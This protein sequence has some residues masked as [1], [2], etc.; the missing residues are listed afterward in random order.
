M[1]RIKTK[2]LE[3][4]GQLENAYLIS[5]EKPFNEI[6]QAS[7]CLPLDDPKNEICKPFN[8]VEIIDD[9]NDQYIGLFRIMPSLTS[10][11]ESHNEVR[12]E[13]QHV[14]SSLM[15][16]VLFGY[17]QY[18]NWKTRDVISD[19][20]NRQKTKHWSLDTVDFTRYFHYSFEN[21]SGLLS[22]LFSIASPF[23]EDYEWK[24]NTQ[25][26]PWKLSLVKPS[27]DIRGEIR[28]GKNIRTIERTIDP[29]N[30]TNRI[31][32]LGAGEGVNQLGINSV[33]GGSPYLENMESVELY[34]EKEYIWVDQRFEVA[35]SLKASAKALLDEWSTPKVTYKVSAADL[36]SLPGHEGEV[37]GVGDMIR[38]VDPD[39]GTFTARIVRES[40]SDLAG[41]PYDIVFEIA[42]KSNDITAT[43]SDM[44]RKQQINEV[45]SQGSTNIMP[46]SYVDNADQANPAAVR[47]FLP[48]DLVNVNTLSLTFETEQFRS[49]SK[50]TQGG[51]AVVESTS[52]GGGTTKSTTSGGGTT[53]T[54]SSGGGTSTSTQSGGGSSRTST[55]GGDHRHMI[56][57]YSGSSTSAL[58]KNRYYTRSAG[59]SGY[60]IGLD[61]EST[62]TGDLYTMGSSGSHSHD[63]SI[64]AHSH[65][66]STP[67][68]THSVTIPAH[69]HDVTIPAHT[70]TITLPNHTHEIE[71]G[72]FRLSTTPSQV[73]IKVDGNSVPHSG[74]SATN[75]DL[76]SYL[77]KDSSGKITRGTWHEIELTPNGRGRINANVIARLFIQ[78]RTGG[79]Y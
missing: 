33:N 9:T 1:L 11:N 52:S 68:H 57:S 4:V 31:Y 21:E 58:S 47:I 10:K 73:S 74:N 53:A 41:T 60:N 59:D 20:L 48:D 49:Y 56:A 75:L 38:I 5:Y 16:T 6:P 64:P 35:S 43:Q 46:Y 27:N 51:G 28:Y 36:S 55:A 40:K 25:A 18:T 26:Y 2:D 76:V 17:W 65:D 34:G 14:L 45:Y 39:F 44:E 29:T 61:L 67:N 66:F 71:H 42:N 23:D 72:I 7:F 54:S 30:I 77:A 15:D 32:P 70:H 22:P 19:I 78:S 63:V 3:T 37:F 13:L 79:T 62:T 24:Y 69:S 50:A 12:Y 8:V